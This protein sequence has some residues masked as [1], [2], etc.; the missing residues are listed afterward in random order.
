MENISEWIWPAKL[1]AAAILFVAVSLGF[2]LVSLA[3]TG[4]SSIPHILLKGRASP[5]FGFATYVIIANAAL[6][7]IGWWLTS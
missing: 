2:L 1:L 4:I 5:H 3:V 7:A 6:F